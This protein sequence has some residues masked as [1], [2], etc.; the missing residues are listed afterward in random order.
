MLS[1]PLAFSYAG[2]LAG[3][4]LNVFYGFITCYTYVKLSAPGTAISPSYSSAK[5]LARIILSDPRLRSYA[6]IGRK[7]FGPR[8]TLAISIMFCLELF[9]VRS[10]FFD[11][12]RFSC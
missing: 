1:E 9:A 11:D 5:I 8:S 3:T 6:D 4:A 12:A 2:W 7:A 10:A